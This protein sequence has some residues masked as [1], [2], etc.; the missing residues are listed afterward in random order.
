MNI[1]NK[2]VSYTNESYH[3][4]EISKSAEW[5]WLDPLEYPEYQK[6]PETL[7]VP[8]DG[9][10][11]CVAEFRK[12]TNIPEGKNPVAHINIFAD[13]K[14]RL[15]VNGEF[16]GTGPIAAGG[17][18]GNRLPMPKQYFNRYTV[19]LSGTSFDIFAQVH[20]MREVMTDY[21]CGQGGFIMSCEITYDDREAFMIVTDSSWLARLNP[22]YKTISSHDTSLTVPEW[23][24]AHVINDGTEKIW[25]LSFADIPMLTEETI[26]PCEVISETKDNKFISRVIFDKI[27]SAYGGQRRMGRAN[28]PGS[29]QTDL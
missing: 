1:K 7:F 2:N 10:R 22:Q 20:I 25:N 29:L 8:N 5:L 24:K 19:S 6:T 26:L 13:T 18:F 11:F 14:F 9:F 16:T 17:D 21:S 3:F 15:Y 12:S 4:T 28:D 23:E 27:Y